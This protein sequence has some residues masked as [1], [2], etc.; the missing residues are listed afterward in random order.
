MEKNETPFGWVVT[1]G[2]FSE[3]AEDEADKMRF[4]GKQVRL[5]D[6]KE[7]AKMLIE[8]GMSEIQNLWAAR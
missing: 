8:F 4:Q 6:G 2:R 7:L 5:I 1:C 3:A